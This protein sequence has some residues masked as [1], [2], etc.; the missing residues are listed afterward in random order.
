MLGTAGKAVNPKSPSSLP[1]PGLQSP[2]P[3]TRV[4][5][6][7]ESWEVGDVGAARER[8]SKEEIWLR[9]GAAGGGICRDEGLVL[10]SCS[11]LPRN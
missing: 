9:N 3:H 2:G 4:S 1:S 7:K 10:G 11:T 5:A 8:F 6:L